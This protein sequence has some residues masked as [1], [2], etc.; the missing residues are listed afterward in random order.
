MPECGAMVSGEESWRSLDLVE[1]GA[2]G[3][4]A[5][6]ALKL[7]ALELR[8]ERVAD[9]VRGQKNATEP[10]DAD[11]VGQLQAVLLDASQI[12]AVESLAATGEKNSRPTGEPTRSSFFQYGA[13]GKLGS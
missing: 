4:A 13:L 7:R 11:R 12:S 5:D 2:A 8:A 1:K 3:V 6:D 10:V 9:L